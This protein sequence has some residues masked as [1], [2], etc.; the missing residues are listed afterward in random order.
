MQ[1]NTAY[2]WR[3]LLF[4]PSVGSRA[5][6][7]E[8]LAWSTARLVAQSSDFRGRFEPVLAGLR[9]AAAGERFDADGRHGSGARRFLGWSIGRHWLMPTSESR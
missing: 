5:E 7:D 8:F 6:I 2:A 4:Y 1:K 3:Q 9:L